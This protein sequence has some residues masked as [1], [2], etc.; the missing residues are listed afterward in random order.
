MYCILQ[1]CSCGSW[2]APLS[3]WIIFVFIHS[4]IHVI[5]RWLEGFLTRNTPPAAAQPAQ[6]VSV[7]SVNPPSTLVFPSASILNSHALF[8]VYWIPLF[9]FLCPSFLCNPLMSCVKRSTYKWN[10]PPN[11]LLRRL[12]TA[13]GRSGNKWSLHLCNHG[14]GMIVNIKEWHYELL[15]DLSVQRETEWGFF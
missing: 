15:C 14:K 13:R 12:V 11:I 5:V 2:Q 7:L 9:V 6:S 3:S 8:S 4:F 10:T 1:S